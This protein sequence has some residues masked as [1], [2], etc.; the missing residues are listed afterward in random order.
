[1]QSHNYGIMIYRKYLDILLSVVC[2]A[3]IL[4]G[5]TTLVSFYYIMTCWTF[6]SCKVINWS[7]GYFPCVLV[8]DFLGMNWRLCCDG[9]ICCAF[10][11]ME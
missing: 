9:V 5:C 1:M 6:H 7:N 10:A 8:E 2:L 3:R 4:E 11:V